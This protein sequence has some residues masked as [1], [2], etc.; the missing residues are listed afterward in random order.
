MRDL[1]R[2]GM[3]M[4]VVTH[5]MQFAREVG[6]RLVFM[7]EG[8]IVEEGVPADVLDRPREERTRRFLRRSLQLAGS[9]ERVVSHR[10]GRSKCMKRILLATAGVAVVR[11]LRRDDRLRPARCHDGRRQAPRR[12]RRCRSCRRTSSQRQRFIVG[13]KCDAPP[14]GYIN[15]Q[16]KNAGFD[17]EIAKWFARYAFGRESRVSY[18]CAPTAGPRAAPHGRTA[19]TSSSRPSPTRPTAT[20]GSTSRAPTTRRPAGC[21]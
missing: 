9:L 16:G 3:T 10:R 12:P 8:R 2:D 21:S 1:A 4:L 17:V 19:S 11:G 14:F 13:V 5:E 20:R 7:D 18:V 15:V 6:D